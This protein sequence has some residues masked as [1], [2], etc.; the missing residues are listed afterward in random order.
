MVKGSVT[1]GGLWDEEVET[2]SGKGAAFEV[3]V[4][5][6]EVRFEFE[7]EEFVVVDNEEATQIEGP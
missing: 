1:A 6:E 2:V 5:L 3:D 4:E 7:Y